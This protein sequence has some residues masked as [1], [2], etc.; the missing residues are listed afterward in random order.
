MRYPKY[1]IRPSDGNIFIMIEE[2]IYSAK[3]SMEEWPNHIHPK[4]EYETL[5]RLKFT[6]C[7]TDAELLLGVSRCFH[8]KKKF[9]SRDGDYHD[10]YQC[11]DCGRLISVRI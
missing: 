4:H 9:H 5:K 2:G 11:L 8:T 1:M 3:G 6:P 7:Y 10:V